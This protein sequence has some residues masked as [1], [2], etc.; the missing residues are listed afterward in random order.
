MRL[1]SSVEE[2]LKIAE[3]DTEEE[4]RIPEEL[5]EV[6]SFLQAFKLTP[7]R[8]KVKTKY[9]YKLYRKW[10]VEPITHQT[11]T[12]KVTTFIKLRNGYF[13]L[14]K[15][16]LK[17]YD[18]VE[19]K[20]T[21]KKR[22]KTINDMKKVK[23]FILEKRWS[24]GRFYYRDYIFLYLFQDWAGGYRINHQ[25]FNKV[26]VKTMNTV[27]G[28]GKFKSFGIDTNL[29]KKDL[30]VEKVNQYIERYENDKEK[31]KSRK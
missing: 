23:E 14:N 9:I 12:N 27:R 7:G 2:L 5:A 6:Y 29:F 25:T 11:F 17:I 16:V 8:H 18:L 24:K 26:M 22:H 19:G 15:D 21:S 3:S 13:M 4:A 20:T 31:R 1:K 28:H 30:T 10:S